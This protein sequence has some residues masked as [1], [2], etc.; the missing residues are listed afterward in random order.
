MSN[1]RNTKNISNIDIFDDVE[2]RLFCYILYHIL[3][4]VFYTILILYT[5][6]LYT[7]TTLVILITIYSIWG[8]RIIQITMFIGSLVLYLKLRDINIP[9]FMWCDAY[10]YHLS[11]NALYFANYVMCL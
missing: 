9:F 8:C 11:M 1:I 6:L 4:M 2:N 10:D 3:A 5:H 7:V